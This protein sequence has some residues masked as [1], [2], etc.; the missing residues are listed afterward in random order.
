M[1]MYQYCQRF[2][3]VSDMN[4]DMAFTISDVWA[5]IKLAW[6][7]PSNALIAV[8]HD[9]SLATFFEVDCTTGQGG[10]G[11]VLSFLCWLAV[12]GAL[13]DGMGK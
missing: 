5:L 1:A 9:T 4:G 2:R 10:G 12:C 11:A 6:L 7:L 3:F 13:A 8:I